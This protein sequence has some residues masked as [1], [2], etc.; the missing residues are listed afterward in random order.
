MAIKMPILVNV[1]C[2]SCGDIDF[3]NWSDFGSEQPC[4]SCDAPA[5]DLVRI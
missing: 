3:A 1:E 2:L 5:I 4:L